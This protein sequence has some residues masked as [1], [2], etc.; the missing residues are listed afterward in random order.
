MR[1]ILVKTILLLIIFCSFTTIHAKEENSLYHTE[2]PVNSQSEVDRIQGI[3]QGMEQIFIKLTGKRDIVDNPAIKPGLKNAENYITQF[4]YTRSPVNKPF[5]LQLDFD[6]KEINHL[7]QQAH[8]PT[9]GEN[10]PLIL[11]WVEYEL[12]NQPAEIIA[13]SQHEIAIDLKQEA[14]RRGLPLVLPAMDMTDMNHVNV[15]DIVMMQL[16]VLQAAAK[17]YGN[18][19]IVVG[20]IFRN[21]NGSY[22]GQWQLSEANHDLEHWEVEGKT[23]NE[24]IAVVIDNTADKMANEYAVVVNDAQ[25]T[26]LTLKIVG[27]SEQDDF[28]QLMRYLKHLTPVAEVALVGANGDTVVLDVS[29]RGTKDTFSQSIADEDTLLPITDETSSEVMSYRWN[30]Y[31]SH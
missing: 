13:D 21:A 12:P 31:Y 26:K 25:Q 23:L 24:V 10:R 9:W 11:A 17:R 5:L 30:S 2:V 27:I 15:N 3:K 1:R 28:A 7:L 29:V 14:A 20:R 19:A 4:S 6:A 8:I 16:P 22:R 18:D